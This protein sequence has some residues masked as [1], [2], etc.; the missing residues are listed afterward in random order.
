MK[1]STLCQ[2][3]AWTLS[4]TVVVLAFV[5]WGSDNAWQFAE[6][7]IYQVF[8]LLGLLAFSIMWSHY[9]SSTIRQLLGIEYAVL[10]PYFKLTSYAVLGLLI[11]HPGLLIYQRFQDGYGLPPGSFMTYVAPAMA[12]LTLLG[13]VCLFAFLA[14]EFHRLYKERSW[15]HYVTKAS[16]L[17]MLGIFYHGL[18][19]GSQLSHSG[20]YQMVWW[21][22]GLSLAA[23][24]LRK[25]Y[26]EY[27]Q[28]KPSKKPSPPA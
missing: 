11:L 2:I 24:L 7:S 6:L 19:L 3:I 13:T 21:F 4:F 9:I 14:F 12:W 20:W 27:S 22:Y 28:L 5:S 8:P 1:R 17:A 10:R 15:W 26:L 16:D 23:V 18:R 25:Y